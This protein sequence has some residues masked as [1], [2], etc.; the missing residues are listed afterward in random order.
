M[1]DHNPSAPPQQT[2]IWNSDLRPEVENLHYVSSIDLFSFYGIGTG[3]VGRIPGGR[4]RDWHF[5]RTAVTI[6]YI[7]V[8][9]GRFYMVRRARKG[10]GW[11]V[12]GWLSPAEVKAHYGAASYQRALFRILVLPICL[13]AVFVVMFAW[14]W[15]AD[16]HDPRFIR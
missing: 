4:L 12:A 3:L 11:E 14:A 1:H 5:K 10:I 16:E 13:A 9:L 2:D 15:W 7:P 6:F 8:W